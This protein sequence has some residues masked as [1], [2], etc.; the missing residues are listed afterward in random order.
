[1]EKTRIYSCLQKYLL[2]TSY[3][4]SPWQVSPQRW[5]GG[6]TTSCFP[7]PWDFSHIVDR[8]TMV[9]GK[10]IFPPL[11]ELTGHQIHLQE[12]GTKNSG[13]WRRPWEES[14]EMVELWKPREVSVAEESSPATRRP[15]KTRGEVCPT[16][17][18]K[19]ISYSAQSSVTAIFDE[20]WGRRDIKCRQLLPE[21]WLWQREKSWWR[22]CAELGT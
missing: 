2:L 5:R 10:P 9:V 15:S 11:T 13:H 12:R 18:K 6:G 21:V 8:E 20:R 17:N 4:L 14:Q 16:S 7:S 1:M 22:R 3:L 19:V